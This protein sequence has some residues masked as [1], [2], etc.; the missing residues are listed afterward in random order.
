MRTAKNGDTNVVKHRISE[1]TDKT[2]SLWQGQPRMREKWDTVLGIHTLLA[3]LGRACTRASAALQTQGTLSR[4]SA[5]RQDW[6]GHAQGLG[7]TR[8]GAVYARRFLPSRHWQLPSCA[9]L[10]RVFLHSGGPCRGTAPPE[11][12]GQPSSPKHTPSHCSLS[13]G[14]FSPHTWAWPGLFS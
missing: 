7:Y 5:L 9:V 13:T 2:A 12:P 1:E 10:G 11:P 14:T 8:G 4:A 3:E 6:D